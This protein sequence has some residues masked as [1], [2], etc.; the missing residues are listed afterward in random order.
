MDANKHALVN[1]FF[2]VPKRCTTHTFNYT[3][4][5]DTKRLDYIL[6]LQPHQKIVQNVN[7]HMQPLMDSKHNIVCATARL[8]G[9]FTRNRKQRA[10][11]GCRSIDR[12]TIPSDTHRHERLIQ[13]VTSQLTQAKLGRTVGGKARF[14]IHT[15]SVLSLQ[16]KKLR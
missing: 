6:P 9:G 8:P 14:L 12:R 7:V 13:F 2:T 5:A 1:M 3:R 16:L 11:T 10:P 4:P 15:F